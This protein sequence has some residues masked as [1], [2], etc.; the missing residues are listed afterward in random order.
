MTADPS[1]IVEAPALPVLNDERELNA[2]ERYSLVSQHF[3]E[4]LLAEPIEFPADSPNVRLG[5]PG[6]VMRGSDIDNLQPS[7]VR[8]PP[9]A[10][11]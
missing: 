10:A 7:T 6:A 1:A 3:P 4:W 8:H 9:T 11:V 5:V 2:D